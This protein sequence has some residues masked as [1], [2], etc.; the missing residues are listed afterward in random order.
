MYF[1]TQLFLA[2]VDS[3]FTL[4]INVK[5]KGKR[6]TKRFFGAFYFSF[7]ILDF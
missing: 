5:A 6:S 2:I 3:I 7:Q 1:E 4:E